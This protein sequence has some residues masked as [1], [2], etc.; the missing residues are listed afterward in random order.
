M[1]KLSPTQKM[2]ASAI[3]TAILVIVFQVFVAFAIPVNVPPV[4][5]NGVANLGAAMRNGIICNGSETY[6]VD[7]RN[8]DIIVY[9]DAAG[10]TPV[11]QLGAGG[12]VTVSQNISVGGAY[13]GITPVATATPIAGGYAFTGNVSGVPTFTS[14]GVRADTGVYTTSVS[15]AGTP[16]VPF[17]TPHTV[18]NSAANGYIQCANTNVTNSATATPVAGAT[19][20]G[21]PWASMS[22]VTGDSARVSAIYSTGVF[23]I[24]V[25]NSALTPAAN[26][27]PVA[28]Q[29]CY[30]YTK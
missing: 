11:V 18:I 1:E 25:T 4:P 21:N 3:L 19:P 13:V 27:T 16:V 12:Y 5:S 8:K 22:A 2:I 24:A 29:W 20:V 17:A 28:V 30:I 10:T 15:I 14:G 6:C 23:T 26:T 9:S 7:S